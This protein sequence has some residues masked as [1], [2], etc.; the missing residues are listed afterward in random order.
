MR[1]RYSTIDSCDH[2]WNQTFSY[3]WQSSPTGTEAGQ[4]QPEPDLLLI[5]ILL[6]VQ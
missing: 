2:W 5:R 4:M 6:Q 3:Q 1:W